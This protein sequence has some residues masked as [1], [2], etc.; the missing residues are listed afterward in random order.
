MKNYLRRYYMLRL[1]H[2]PAPIAALFALR[3]MA[4]ALRA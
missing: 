1:K 2:Y 4:Y 3:S